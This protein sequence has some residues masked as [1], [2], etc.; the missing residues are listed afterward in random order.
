MRA[1]GRG[2]QVGVHAYGRQL[3]GRRV[4][5]L[6]GEL[7]AADPGDV[8][9]AAWSTEFALA[10]ALTDQPDRFAAPSPSD[11]TDLCTRLGSRTGAPAKNC[12]KRTPWLSSPKPHSKPP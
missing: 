12:R 8:L 7:L 3:T 5:E 11:I 10:L 6:F 1:R 9:A 2:I 4:G